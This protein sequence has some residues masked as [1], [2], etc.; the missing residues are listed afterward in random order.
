MK[1]DTVKAKEDSKAA[2]HPEGTWDG[3]VIGQEVKKTKT[4]RDMIVLSWKTS[5]GK[6][7]TY[8]A[9]VEEYP[10]LFLK[11]MYAL[12]LT[13][14]FFQA[15]PELEDVAMELLKKRALLD[16]THEEYQGN[17]V[18]S[19]KSINRIPDNGIKAVPDVA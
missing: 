5:Q 19:I 13:E 17:P 16:V 9:Y 8:H 4:D 6:L 18:A 11:P 2:L 3:T 15:D 14:E 12:G 7:K 1:F 10:G